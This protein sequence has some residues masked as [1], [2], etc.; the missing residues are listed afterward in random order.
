[1]SDTINR[2][3]PRTQLPPVLT[4][5]PKSTFFVDTFMQGGEEF[6][7]TEN[8]EWDSVLEG[9]PTARF[10]GDDMT[11]EA[12]ERTPYKTNEI[13]T[14]IMQERRVISA[15]DIAKRS[16]GE[17]IY[18]AMTPEQRALK[19]IAEDVKFCLN[20]IDMRIEIMV[21]QL[22]TKGMVD[23]SYTGR[24]NIVINQ[25]L[26]YQLPNKTVLTGGDRWGQTG[27]NIIDSMR[28]QVDALG[29][30]GYT[31]DEIIMS[32]EVWAVIYQDPNI[33]K[34]LDIRRFEFGVFKPEMVSKYGAA[35]V[36]GMLS[37]PFVT[38]YTQNAEFG[39]KS[40]RQRFL[41]AGTVLFVTRESKQ[42]K[43][44]FGA[45]TLMDEAEQFRTVSGRYVQEFFRERR[46]A[47]E[48]VLVTSRAVPIPFNTESWAVMQVL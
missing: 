3:D 46:P 25:T 30:L 12:S 42:N 45:V 16:A 31:V 47:R 43:L 37:D 34:L 28:E 44:G 5:R 18:S 38:L 29:H 15:K 14:P 7:P 2:F 17:N 39:G 13:K 9:A 26:D 21:S 11:V 24:N 48:E 1:M 4:V 27:V 23:I 10:V 36:V 32:P 35:R 6:F 41:P 20:S 33:Q 8:V 22:I 19:Y 40:N